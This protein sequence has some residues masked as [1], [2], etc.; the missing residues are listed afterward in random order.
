MLISSNAIPATPPPLLKDAVSGKIS[1]FLHFVLQL[2]V[3]FSERLRKQEKV[4]MIKKEE[5]PVTVNNPESLP[6]YWYETSD[7]VSRRFHFESDGHLSVNLS[8]PPF[9]SP[10]FSDHGCFFSFFSLDETC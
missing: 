1:T 2:D 4:K 9:A 5:P 10:I 7:S 3:Q 8:L 6:L